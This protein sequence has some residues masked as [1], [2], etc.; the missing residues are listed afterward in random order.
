MQGLVSFK[1][2]ISHTCSHSETL[3]VML[4]PMQRSGRGLR[5]A[6][7]PQRTCR[8]CPQQGEHCCLAEQCVGGAQ[9]SDGGC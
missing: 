9:L 3:S 6:T 1:A 4:T 5:A 2:C 8:V 7:F